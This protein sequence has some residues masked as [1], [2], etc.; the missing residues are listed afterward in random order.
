M[1]RLFGFILVFLGAA[2]FN[3]VSGIP[4]LPLQTLYVNFTVDLFLAIGIGLGAASPGLMQRPPRGS[5]AEI[6]PR[7]TLFG[8]AALGLVL[9]VCTLGIMWSAQGTLGE[10]VAR[11]MGLVTF[12]L[13]GIFLALECNDDTG[14]V[15]G[16]ATLNN[17]KLIQMSVFALVATIAVT[18]LGLFQRIFDTV[19]L[20]ASQW[21]TCL[22]VGSVIVW[23]MEVEKLIRRRRI[24]REQSESAEAPVVPAAAA[25]A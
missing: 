24:A 6:L 17:G 12:A 16:M 1:A 8:L 20:N 7:R 2:L 23:V 13:A 10:P 21:V 9:A 4:F 11:S 22:V 25:T 19:S 14:S 15:F 3:I 5:K 18:E